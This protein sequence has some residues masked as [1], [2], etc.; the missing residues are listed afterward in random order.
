MLNKRRHA[1]AAWMAGLLL[2]LASGGGAMAQTLTQALEAAWARSAQ[3]ATLSARQDEA[4]AGSDLARGLTP[5]PAAV[6]LNQLNDRFNQNTGRREWEVE[7]AVP[8]WLPGPR[9]FS[10]R[11]TES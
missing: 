10:M 11:S 5:G 3:A 6:S 4:Q 2:V 7:V 9:G 1:Q 8:L